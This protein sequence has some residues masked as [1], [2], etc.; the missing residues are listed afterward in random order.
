MTGPLQRKVDLHVRSAFSNQVSRGLTRSEL[1][2]AASAG[3]ARPAQAQP[4]DGGAS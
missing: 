4:D 3:A 2:I 1:P